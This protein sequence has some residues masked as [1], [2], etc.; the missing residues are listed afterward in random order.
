MIILIKIHLFNHST[1]PNDKTTLDIFRTSR[2]REFIKVPKRSSKI[3]FIPS[4]LKVRYG[5]SNRLEQIFV[6]FSKPITKIFPPI[7]KL[8]KSLMPFKNYGENC[9]K[10]IPSLYVRCSL[11]LFLSQTTKFNYRSLLWILL[12]ISTLTLN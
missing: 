11:I 4:S 10:M 8:S 9:L 3:Q 6:F 12:N 2:P 1:D 7:T 5:R